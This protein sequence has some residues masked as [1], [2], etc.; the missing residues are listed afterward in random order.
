MEVISVE[1]IE[2]YHAAPG[3][4]L[5]FLPHEPI[6]IILRTWHPNALRAFLDYETYSSFQFDICDKNANGKTW[7]THSIWRRERNVRF[8]TSDQNKIWHLD[9]RY[10]ILDGAPWIPLGGGSLEHGRSSTPEWVESLARS[11]AMDQMR[12]RNWRCRNNRFFRFFLNDSEVNP[13]S[14]YW[15]P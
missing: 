10:G 12:E 15:D 4:K 6:A 7:R 3:P 11:W 13:T 1:E 14:L 5:A 9:C 2:D 8:G